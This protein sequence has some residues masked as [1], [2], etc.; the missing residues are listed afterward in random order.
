MLDEMGGGVDLSWRERMDEVAVQI[1]DA[2]EFPDELDGGSHH[3]SS[4]AGYCC[5]AFV[6]VIAVSHLPHNSCRR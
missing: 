5:G 6:D 4:R 3:A 2:S 1:T